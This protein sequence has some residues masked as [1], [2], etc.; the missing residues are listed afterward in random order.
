MVF[1]QEI[2]TTGGGPHFDANDIWTLV[3]GKLPD[4]WRGCG[5]AFRTVLGKHEASCIRLAAIAIVLR[6]H[7]GK[8][9]GLLSGHI[10]HK[11]T[12]QQTAAALHDWEKLPALQCRRM[13]LGFDANE[14]FLQP[15]GLLGNA[16]LSCTGRGEQILQWLLEQDVHLPLQDM[17]LPSHFPY[18]PNFSARRIDYVAARHVR[19]AQ[20]SVGCARTGPRPTTNPSWPLPS[21][22]FQIGLKLGLSGAPA[23]SNQSANSFLIRSNLTGATPIE[24]CLNCRPPSLSL[25]KDRLS[26]GKVEPLSCSAVKLGASP[27]GLIAGEGGK[28]LPVNSSKKGKPGKQIWPAKQALTTGMHCAHSKPKVPRPTGQ[29]PSWTTRTGQTASAGTCHP[30]FASSRQVSLGQPCKPCVKKLPTCAKPHHGGPSLSK[31]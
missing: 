2:T 28:L 5:I 16:T 27:L 29:L 20:A 4:E 13:C 30:S 1:L 22:P 31:R 24:P 15:G 25:L 26:S 8:S 18:N 3:H 10:S 7:N 14:T 21:C 19:V 23:N 17:H 9:V 12:I 11:F 6:L